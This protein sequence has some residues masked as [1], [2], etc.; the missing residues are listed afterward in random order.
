[1]SFMSIVNISSRSRSA[2]PDRLD[3]NVGQIPTQAA[4]MPTPQQHDPAK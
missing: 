1:M 3:S 2:F 4:A